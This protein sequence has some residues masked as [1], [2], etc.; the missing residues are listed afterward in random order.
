[1][2][3]KVTFLSILIFFSTSLVA[4]PGIEAQDYLNQNSI[5]EQQVVLPT[6][7]VPAQV[8]IP[9]NHVGFGLPKLSRPA[10]F[11][12]LAASYYLMCRITLGDEPKGTLGCCLK[13][14]A[15]TGLAFSGS[16]GLVSAL[17]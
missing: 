3:M 12:V 4:R 11:A 16:Y 13:L 7:L 17:K 9:V 8:N 14:G 10:G 6:Q 1:M 2:K 5:D 15:V